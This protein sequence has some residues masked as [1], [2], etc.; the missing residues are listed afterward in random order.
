MCVC[1][2]FLF[3]P[4][5]DIVT[6]TNLQS[7]FNLHFR[8]DDVA[9][10]SNDRLQNTYN[11]RYTSKQH[12]TQRWNV[13]ESRKNTAPFLPLPMCFVFNGIGIGK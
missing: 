9:I 5:C 8:F 7:T 6:E 11:N 13:L 3:S 4:A 12:Q 10:L 2:C 1:L